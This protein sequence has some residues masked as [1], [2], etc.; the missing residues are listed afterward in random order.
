MNERI[1]IIDDEQ[2]SLQVLRDIL[3]VMGY[4]VEAKRTGHEALQTFGQDPYGFDAIISDQYL[5]ATVRGLT[6]AKEFLKIRSDTPIIIWT[7]DIEEIREEANGLGIRW[8]LQKP[9]TIGHLIGTVIEAL[10]NRPVNRQ[11]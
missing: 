5:N 3:E 11:V 1:L 2:I 7:G 4:R 6:L 10:R 9:V 8:L